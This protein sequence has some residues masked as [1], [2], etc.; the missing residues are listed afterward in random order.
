MEPEIAPEAP[1]DPDL[2]LYDRTHLITYLRMLDA[3]AEGA[4]WDEVAQIVL[5]IDPVDEPQAARRAYDTHL[6]RAQWM[7][8]A[9][10]KLLL[11][12]ARS[13]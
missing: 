6:R 3:D 11:Q 9:G 1:S 10:H 5:G 13:S 7:T 2:T 12:N 8:E 4:P